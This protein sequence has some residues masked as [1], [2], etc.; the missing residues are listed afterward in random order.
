VRRVSDEHKD[1]LKYVSRLGI[2]LNRQLR[3]KE[4]IPFD[5]SLR[6]EIGGKEHFVS[7]RLAENIF[8]EVVRRRKAKEHAG[9]V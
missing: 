3:V 1:V 6:V 5:G 8:V 7:A 4:R 9:T 2:V